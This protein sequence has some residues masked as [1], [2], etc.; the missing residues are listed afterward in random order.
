LPEN[1]QIGHGKDVSIALC[2]SDPADSE[3]LLSRR[4]DEDVPLDEARLGSEVGKLVRDLLLFQPVF[5]FEVDLARGNF[6]QGCDD[7]PV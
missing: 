6:P 3:L 5:L 4:N 2:P 1:E 7:F